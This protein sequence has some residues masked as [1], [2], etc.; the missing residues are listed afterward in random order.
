[1]PST[2]APPSPRDD[3]LFPESPDQPHWP[4]PDNLGE[5]QVESVCPMYFVGIVGRAQLW[6]AVGETKAAHEG[7]GARVVPKLRAP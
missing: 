4:T 3:T 6:S 2:T 5:L 7:Q 1:M